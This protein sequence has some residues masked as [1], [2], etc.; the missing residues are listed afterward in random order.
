M[1]SPNNDNPSLEDG[2]GGKVQATRIGESSEGSSPLAS[3]MTRTPTSADTAQ[4]LTPREG[5][6]PPPTSN[7]S[8]VTTQSAPGPTIVTLEPYQTQRNNN[9]NATKRNKE[10]RVKQLLLMEQNTR[11]EPNFAKFYIMKFPRLDIDTKLNV[12]ATDKEIKNKIGLPRKISK[13]NK[14]SLLIEVKTSSQGK[15]LME[16]KRITGLEVTINEHKSM[17]QSKG[18]LY[19]ETLSNSTEEELLECLQEQG[20]IKIE[21]MKRREYGELVETHRYILTFN[22]TELP[23]LIRLADWHHEP[24]DLYIPPPLR[25]HQCQRLGHTKSRCSRT[26]VTCSRCGVEG[27]TSHDCQNEP[28]CIN[29]NGEHNAYDKQCPFY[30]FKCEVIATHTRQRIPYGEAETIVREQYRQE[31]KTYSFRVRS[32]LN[33]TQNQEQRNAHQAQSQEQVNDRQTQS[34]EQTNSQQNTQ[35]IPSSNQTLLPS[36]ISLS[37]P[38]QTNINSQLSGTPSLN[39]NEN[40]GPQTQ[41]TDKD[42]NAIIEDK[43]PMPPLEKMQHLDRKAEKV[44]SKTKST[45]GGDET[46]QP[47]SHKGKPAEEIREVPPMNNPEK[48]LKEVPNKEQ[49]KKTT[50]K[51]SNK[52]EKYERRKSLT[53]NTENLSTKNDPQFRKERKYS[54]TSNPFQNINRTDDPRKEQRGRKRGEDQLSSSPELGN[55]K[56]PRKPPPPPPTDLPGNSKSPIPVINSRFPLQGNPP[57]MNMGHH[58]YNSQ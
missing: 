48:P 37:L 42:S 1:E 29:C 40:D 54:L 58:Y 33:R 45:T 39:Q 18:T 25:C 11:K 16:L 15:K 19:S 31:N 52:P 24:I 41:E 10:R 43:T 2:L 13:L 44:R 46:P 56:I 57:P 7:A 8:P 30:L 14:D 38:S 23:P 22:R 35:E 51:N 27:H 50:K 28:H 34:Q 47:S 55:F 5:N 53:D 3:P 36:Q 49:P 6:R 17:N 12:I 9:R 21:R 4:A 20:V 32:R 26:E